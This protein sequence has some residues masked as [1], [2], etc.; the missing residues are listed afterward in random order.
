MT[1]KA[2]VA[3]R[4]RELIAGDPV[5]DTK[6]IREAADLLEAQSADSD[7]LAKLETRLNEIGGSH[8]HMASEYEAISRRLLEIVKVQGAA[9]ATGDMVMVPRHD[10]SVLVQTLHNASYDLNTSQLDGQIERADNWLAALRA[11][12]ASRRDT[13]SDSDLWEIYSGYVVRHGGDVLKVK[14]E[15]IRPFVQAAMDALHHVAVSG[16]DAVIEKCAKA[17][18]DKIEGG[19]C[20]EGTVEIIA[21]QSRNAVLRECAEIV[22]A[23]KS[24]PAKSQEGE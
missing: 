13:E 10:L 8:V 15:T 22:L 4:L 23:L 9:P 5:Y 20:G 18:L 6:T 2:S 16:R 1:D 12:P 3:V 14:A 24:P 7:E 11:M 21:R 19:H 17:L